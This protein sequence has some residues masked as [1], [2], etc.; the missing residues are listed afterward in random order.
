MSINL[1]C[2]LCLPDQPEEEVWLMQTPSFD[3]DM[4]MGHLVSVGRGK[5]ARLERSMY[6]WQTQA[7]NYLAWVAQRYDPYDRDPA[8]REDNRE[9]W[10]RERKKIGDAWRRAEEGNGR[11]RFTAW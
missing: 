4:I 9:V 5:K 8:R 3:T 2:F 10:K 7:K 1:H 6:N 11:L